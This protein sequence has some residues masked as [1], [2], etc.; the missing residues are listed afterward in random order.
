MGVV[1][2]GQPL[3]CGN[4]R[5]RRILRWRPTKSGWEPTQASACPDC[6]T[7]KA[8]V[9]ARRRHLGQSCWWTPSK[10]SERR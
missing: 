8:Y 5:C 7:P 6:F 1:P 10:L 2:H 9:A 4:N 3:R